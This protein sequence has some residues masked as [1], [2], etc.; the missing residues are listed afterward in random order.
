ML[1]IT[2]LPNLIFNLYTRQ[3]CVNG[4]YR[5]RTYVSRRVAFNVYDYSA[6][7]GVLTA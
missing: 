7:P 5:N 2:L 6:A 3:L 4:K 1:P